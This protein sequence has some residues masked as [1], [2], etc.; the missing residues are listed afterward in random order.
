MSHE[1][2]TPLNAISGFVELLEMGISGPVNH[3][4][5]VVLARI[6]ANQEHL[7]ALI[8]EVLNFVRVESGRTE[9]RFTHVS[10]RQALDDV[11][12]MLSGEVADKGLSLDGPRGGADAVAW[13]DPD[14]VRQILLNLVMNAVKYSPPNGG[15]VSLSCAVDG[16][17]AMAHVSDTGPGIPPDKLDAIFEPFVQ[18]TPG[19]PNRRGGIGLGLAI[20]RDLAHAMAGELRLESAV[21]VG[22]RFTLDLP[23]LTRASRGQ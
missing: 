9:Y 7:L 17:R 14:R 6:K 2:R 5:Q 1:L 11:A 16:D 15:T 21:G 13:A 8:T 12:E 4:Q 18:L 20:S 10:L 19:L 23:A 22:S 3:E